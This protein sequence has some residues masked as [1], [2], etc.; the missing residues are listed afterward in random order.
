MP[1]SITDL[2][3]KQRAMLD[4]KERRLAG[5]AGMTA[6]EAQEKYLAGQEL[7]LQSDIANYLRLHQIE[8]IKPDPR[9]KSPLPPGWPDFTFAY[10]ER[11][12]GIEAKSSV[13][14]LGPDQIQQ[15]ERMR[16]NGWLIVVARSVADVQAA[17]RRVDEELSPKP[18]FSH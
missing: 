10:R 7:A 2:T 16:K 1:I 9:K 18:S 4:P 15:H 8:Y 17:L 14:K 5:R 11:A 13:G 6:Q 12:I 3:D